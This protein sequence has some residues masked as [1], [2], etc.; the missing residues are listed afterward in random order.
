MICKFKVAFT[1]FFLIVNVHLYGN[2]AIDINDQKIHVISLG[3]HKDTQIIKVQIN[4]ACRNPNLVILKSNFDYLYIES[5]NYESGFYLNGQTV[6]KKTV[7]FDDPYPIFPFE[8]MEKFTIKVMSNEPII[9]PIQVIDK[10]ELHHIQF[11]RDVFSSIFI[12]IIISLLLYNLS[13]YVFLRD[14]NYLYYCL[15]LFFISIAQL[16]VTGFNYYMFSGHTQLFSV[17]F[18]LGSGLSG[19]FGILFIQKFLDTRNEAKKGHFFL[20][21]LLGGYAIVV[22]LVTFDKVNLAYQFMQLGG[23]SLVVILFVSSNLTLKGSKKGVYVSISYFV[24]F[25]G[26]FFYTLKDLNIVPFNFW[27]NYTLTIGVAIQAILLSLALADSINALKRE[28]D[29]ANVRAIIEV[30]KNEELIK[31]QNITLE[32]KV[33]ERTAALQ[34]ALDEL[35]AAQSQLVQSEKMA[36]LGTLTAGIAHEINNP[37]NFVSANVIPLRENI[38][39][40]IKLIGAYKSI[41]FSNLK[42]ELKR[43]AGLEEELELDYMLTETKQ[44]IDGIEEGAKRT[45]T[46]V[47]GLTSFSRGDMVTKSGADI[48]R[49]IRSTISVLK[50]R[51]NNV[52]LTTNLDKNLPLVSC[53]IGKINQ[54]VLNLMN[55]ALD[56]LE[57]KNGTNR[58]ASQ[59]TV[60]TKNLGD[61]IQI[62]VSDNANGID[63][64]LQLKIIEPFYTT[65][66]VGKGTGL[67]LSISY[68]II[69]DHG[70]A[71]ELDSEEGVGTKFIITLPIVLQT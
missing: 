18:H 11:Q 54:V 19:I 70:G 40:I 1:L 7:F 60:E 34:E 17:L 31:D 15:Y 61:S 29:E 43:L 50:S 36:S 39:D 63:K 51:L 67:G 55:N 6:A 65:K 56:A 32:R 41:D 57:E 37:I 44:L 47:E 2:N 66:D 9:L 53:Q 4:S 26:I 68:S 49:G 28:K 22:A 71:I 38:N 69:E 5:E 12:G 13:L 48:N 16:D 52:K 35:K 20:N 21:I 46:I 45:H 23:V 14:Y 33:V 25:I 42:S 64:E 30:K 8:R 27:T 3:L 10:S 62:I 24:L 59:L 58:K